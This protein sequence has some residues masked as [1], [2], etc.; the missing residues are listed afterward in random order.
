[1]SG[2]T[3]ESLKVWDLPTR[4]FH[5]MLALLVFANFF[6]GEDE[7]GLLIVHTYCGYLIGLLLIARVAWGVAGNRHARFGD[8]LKPWPETRKYLR[9]LLRLSPPRYVGHNP[10]GG[11]MIVVMLVTLG[12]IVFTGMAAAVGEG[13]RIPFLGGLPDGVS[14][15]S[16]EIHEVA[17]TVMMVLA[18]LHVTGVLVDWILTG[19]N[20]LKAMVT[21]RKT[22]AEGVA[23]A[24]AISAWRGAVLAGFVLLGT[25]WMIDQT[26]FESVDNEHEE[27]AEDYDEEDEEDEDNHHE[28]YDDDD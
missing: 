1:L 8:F 28:R 2:N 3:T 20:I 15:A 26:R 17:A 19:E 6:T 25:G 16:E 7:G 12:L 23:P 10:L 22:P 24:P 27:H 5:W 14:E 11:W 9:Q 13:V 18:G 4:V 21:G